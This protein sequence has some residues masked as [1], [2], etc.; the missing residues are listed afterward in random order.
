MSNR[1]ST[2]DVLGEMLGTP[3]STAATPLA[4]PAPARSTQGR[5]SSF[6]ALRTP[7]TA[8]PT[9]EYLTVILGDHHGLRPKSL[10]GHMLENWKTQPAMPDFLAVV[11]R[12]GW[13]MVAILDAGCGEKEAYFKRRSHAD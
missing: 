6:A 3:G 4:R 11:G 10:N 12:Y 5:S 8:A 9:W 13:E 7:R 1:K 2:P